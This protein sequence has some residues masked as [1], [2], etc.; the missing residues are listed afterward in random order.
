MKARN[1][2]A[3]AAHLRNSGGAMRDRR[4]PR[5]GARNLHAEWLEEAREELAGEDG[6]DVEVRPR[7]EGARGGRG[8]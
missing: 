7:A 2:N 1:W 4:A 3:V 6:T 8:R 5:G